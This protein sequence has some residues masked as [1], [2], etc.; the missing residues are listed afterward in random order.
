MK[1][2]ILFRGWSR[3][4]KRWVYGWLYHDQIFRAGYSCQ[5]IFLIRDACDEDFEVDPASVG[6]YTGRNYQNKEKIFGGDIAESTLNGKRWIISYCGKDMC[7]KIKLIGERTREVYSL[8]Q[9]NR[10]GKF[11]DGRT[12]GDFLKKI[13]TTYENP[14]LVG[15]EK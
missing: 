6:Q 1:R 9:Y 2:E 14:E 5:D 10:F 4:L 11:K 3:E 7:Y 12:A 15:E 13:G 8:Y